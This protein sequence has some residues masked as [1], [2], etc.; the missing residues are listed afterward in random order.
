MCTSVINDELNE[1]WMPIYYQARCRLLQPLVLACFSSALG[2]YGVSTYNGATPEP[3]NIMIYLPRKSNLSI[4][5]VPEL[6][7]F[8]SWI[9]PMPTSLHT[10]ETQKNDLSRASHLELIDTDHCPVSW[11]DWKGELENGRTSSR[12]AIHDGRTITHRQSS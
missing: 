1:S 7:L 12:A 9:T 5:N 6:Q 8:T 11:P 4:T 2:M 10:G 3:P